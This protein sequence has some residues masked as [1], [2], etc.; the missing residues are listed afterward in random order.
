MI[1]SEQ[2]FFCVVPLSPLLM[3]DQ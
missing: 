2:N 3:H 1:F